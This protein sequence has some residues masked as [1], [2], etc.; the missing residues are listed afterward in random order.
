[1]RLNRIAKEFNVGVQT[2]VEFL[3]KKAGVTVEG[4]MANVTDEQYEMLRKDRKSVV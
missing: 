2:L 1:M 3:E 4:P